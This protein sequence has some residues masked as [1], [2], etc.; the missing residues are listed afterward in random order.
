MRRNRLIGVR[1]HLILTCQ[2]DGKLPE[3]IQSCRILHNPGEARLN[4]AGQVKEQMAFPANYQLRAG[5]KRRYK[6]RKRDKFYDDDP[7]GEI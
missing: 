4:E 1:L 2:N 3:A 6:L 5:A 7:G